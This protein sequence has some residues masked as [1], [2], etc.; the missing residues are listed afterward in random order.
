MEL[1]RNAGSARHAHGHVIIMSAAWPER[2]VSGQWECHSNMAGKRPP[3]EQNAGR[4][5]AQRLHLCRIAFPLL[6]FW[7]EA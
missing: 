2:I 4:V 7:I 6:G 3:R 5:F 1:S